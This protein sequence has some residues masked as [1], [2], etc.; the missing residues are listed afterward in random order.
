M[1]KFTIKNSMVVSIV[2]DFFLIVNNLAF[3]EY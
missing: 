2:S 3:L 1:N